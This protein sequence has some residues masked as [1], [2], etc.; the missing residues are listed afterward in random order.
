MSHPTGTTLLELLLTLCLLGLLTGLVGP[1]VGRGLDRFAV[2][3]ARDELTAAVSRTRS[4][5]VSLGGAVLIVDPQH[6]SFW[7][8]SAAGDTVL[9]P[10]NLTARHGVDVE[11]AAAAGPVELAYDGLGIGRIS[12]HTIRLVRG[13]AVAG[14]TISAY[15][16]A[17]AW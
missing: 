17:R 4:A 6:A 2:R 16:R 10:V 15:G 7:I 3:A 12:N 8:R 9:R 13:R 5:A 14:V 11:V 1:A